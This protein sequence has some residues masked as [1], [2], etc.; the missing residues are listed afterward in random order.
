V[1]SRLAAVALTIPIVLATG[2]GVLLCLYLRVATCD[3][4]CEPSGSWH[5]DP[6]AWQWNLFLLLAL[7]GGIAVVVLFVAVLEG[8]SDAATVA[9]V[10][11]ATCGV[12]L[13]TLL[14]AL[15]YRHQ[16]ATGWFAIAVLSLLGF[17][18]IVL[19]DGRAPREG[20]PAAG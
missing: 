17:I 12:A 10:T 5:R 9:L 6:G 4:A 13:Q 20:R 18:A 11:W 7:L 3:E 2:F 16:S 19:A 14:Q 15:G 1:G 8:R